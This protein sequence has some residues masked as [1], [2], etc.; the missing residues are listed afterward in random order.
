VQAFTVPDGAPK[1]R[2]IADENNR[3]RFPETHCYDARGRF[4]NIRA[5]MPAASCVSLQITSL[6][7]TL[8]ARPMN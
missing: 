6:Q 1:T 3:L 4:F 2:A 5:Q 7:I 8:T